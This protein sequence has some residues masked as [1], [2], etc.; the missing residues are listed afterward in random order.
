MRHFPGSCDES[1]N[2]L[3][4]LPKNFGGGSF[5]NSGL[6][7]RRDATAGGGVRVGNTRCCVG[8]VGQ[9]WGSSLKIY[10]SRG[11]TEKEKGGVLGRKWLSTFM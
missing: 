11:G 8:Q 1:L 3:S 4:E 7:D 5:E 10:R 9:F 6:T 2:Y